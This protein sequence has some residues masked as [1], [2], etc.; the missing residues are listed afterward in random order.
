[1]WKLL[2]SMGVYLGSLGCGTALSSPLADSSF[3]ECNGAKFHLRTHPEQQP[4]LPTVILLSGPTDTWASDSA[5]F[6]ALQGH[7]PMRN[8]AID[9]RNQGLSAIGGDGSYQAFAQDLGC[10]L[11]KISKEP[12][13]VL[14]FAS[15]NLTLLHYFKSFGD[16]HISAAL[17][18]DPDGLTDRNVTFYAEQALPF[19]NEKLRDYVMSGKYDE[20]AQAKV[21]ADLAH[22]K[23]IIERQTLAIDWYY[24]EEILKTRVDRER[25]V[26][27]MAD[28]SRY[29]QD[30]VQAHKIPWPATTRVWAID[31]QFE[32]LTIDGSKEEEKKKFILWEADNQQWMRQ[33]PNVCYLPQ[34]STEHILMMEQ[35][36]YVATQLMLLI[37]NANCPVSP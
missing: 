20:R 6:S 35:P 32:K 1:M 9:R 27:Q 18:I 4:G 24:F 16:A 11:P 22:I 2:V 33:L 13:I 8:I 15:S 14:A 25:I 19:Q 10:L 3:V 26:A 37:K 36:Q 12:V 29:D 5:W 17:L 7:L 31:T 34:A 30:I 23:A 28:I 21:A